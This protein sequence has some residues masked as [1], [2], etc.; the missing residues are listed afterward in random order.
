MDCIREAAAP[1]RY[2]TFKRG[3]LRLWLNPP[4]MEIF[5]HGKGWIPYVDLAVG[6]KTNYGEVAFIGTQ[7]E[8]RAY[9]ARLD[10]LY[11]SL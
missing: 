9:R 11:E 1:D 10:E 6:D 2:A 7:A 8:V 4:S 3:G 5:V